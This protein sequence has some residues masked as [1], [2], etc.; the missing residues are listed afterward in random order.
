MIPLPPKNAAFLTGSRAYG[1]PKENSDIDVVILITKEALSKI[2]EYGPVTPDDAHYGSAETGVSL[3]IGNLQ[4]IF[5][6]SQAQYDA[7][8][9]G[10]KELKAKSPVTR[11]EAIEHFK[12][13][14]STL[15]PKFADPQAIQQI[16]PGIP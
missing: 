3:R 11:D 8:L 6:A 9:K 10:T 7:W 4:L 2:F 5:V 12:Q 16:P 13:Y 14:W 15:N 1:I